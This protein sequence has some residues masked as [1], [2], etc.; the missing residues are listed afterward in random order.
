MKLD[1]GVAT[2]K[3]EAVPNMAADR[4]H[5]GEA[6]YNERRILVDDGL[7]GEELS[8][9]VW[10]EVLHFLDTL[11]LGKRIYSID[12][13]HTTLDSLSVLVDQVLRRNW[14]L[15]AKVYGAK[16]S[17][18]KSASAGRRSKKQQPQSRRRG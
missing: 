8:C 1:L 16:G 10:H 15:W 9:T 17:G 12:Q 5:V 13:E 2:V 6:R 4:G 14:A 7:T 11:V 3:V 18:G